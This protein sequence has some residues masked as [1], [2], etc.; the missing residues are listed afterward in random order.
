MAKLSRDIAAQVQA[1]FDASDPQ[2][3]HIWSSTMWEAWEFGRFMS[4]T[5]REIH[6]VEKRRGGIWETPYG[7]AYRMHYS[8][9][10]TGGGLS[11]FGRVK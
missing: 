4:L 7:A 5:G 8:R 11:G 2:N 1:G 6:N 9:M 3:P 10:K